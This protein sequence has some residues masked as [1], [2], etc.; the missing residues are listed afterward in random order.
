MD[1]RISRLGHRIDRRLP[2]SDTRT[3]KNAAFKDAARTK[4]TKADPFSWWTLTC[5]RTR[6][7]QTSHD[8]SDTVPNSINVRH[9][10]IWERRF[11]SVLCY[12]T[13]QKIA[14]IIKATPS[15]IRANRS[16][17][18]NSVSDRTTLVG[19][20][21][22]CIRPEKRPWRRFVDCSSIR[23]HSGRRASGRTSK[24]HRYSLR[25]T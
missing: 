15:R 7:H 20:Q 6:D 14:S 25:R 9:Q 24:R 10:S 23:A 11:A 22:F 4:L 12:G 17:H 5:R 1:A 19:S 2:P 13:K 18:D 16:P 3:T 21:F 8:C